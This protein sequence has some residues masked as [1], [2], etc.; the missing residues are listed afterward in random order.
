[1]MLTYLMPGSRESRHGS[2]GW[3]LIMALAVAVVGCDFTVTNPGPTQDQDLN[4]QSAHS[5]VV[6]GMARGLLEATNWIAYTSALPAHEIFPGGQTGAHGHSV[7]AQQ[8]QLRIDQTNTH[9]ELAQ[10]ARWVAEDGIRRFQE[11]VD[12]TSSYG[13][14]ARAHMWAGFANR[15]LGENMCQAVINGGEAQPA[16]VYLERAESHFTDAIEIAENAGLDRIV[17]ASQGGRASVRVHLGDWAGAVQDAQG[18]PRDFDFRLEASGIDSE[19][20]NRVYWANANQPYRAYTI[21]NTYYDSYY[22]DTGDPR[23]PW[24]EDPDVPHPNAAVQGY[25][26]VPWYFQTKYDSQDAGYMLTDGREMALVRAESL[27]RDGQWQEAMSI[28]NDIRSNVGVEERQ[29]SN[30][31]EAWTH[32]MRERGIELWLE[33]RRLADLERWEQED[34]PGDMGFESWFS[35]SSPDRCFPI[36]ETER[37]TNPNVP[38]S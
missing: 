26:Q 12:E 23:T 38:T 13:P 16:S 37:Q 27:L 29:A 14:L 24:G 5:A 21:W 17:T 31:D 2:V 15:L 19:T 28:I 20:R 4:Q 6:N 3:C 9:W 34:V 30:S 25:G 1:M 35:D 11:E 33:G 10:R 32:L 7:P 22:A 36:P 18:V 8:G